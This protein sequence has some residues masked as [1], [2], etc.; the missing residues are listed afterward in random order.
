LDT[1][2]ITVIK[3]A[4]NVLA[5]KATVKITAVL[6]DPVYVGLARSRSDLE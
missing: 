6:L 2:D 1:I 3:A 5:V 4:M